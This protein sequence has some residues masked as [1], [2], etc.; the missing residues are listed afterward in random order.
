MHSLFPHNPAIVLSPSTSARLR[1]AS[2]LQNQRLA[3]A[4]AQ[5]VALPACLLYHSPTSSTAP[6]SMH[7]TCKPLLTRKSRHPHVIKGH[8][9]RD[10]GLAK[11]EGRRR[12]VREEVGHYLRE[13]RENRSCCFLGLFLWLSGSR[14]QERTRVKGFFWGLSFYLKERVKGRERE[15]IRGGLWLHRSGA[16]LIFFLCPL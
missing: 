5:A 1:P 16:L 6:L 14:K 3:P 4:N 11:F 7:R 12:E 10:Q 15:V 13:K 8:M 2:L 9:T